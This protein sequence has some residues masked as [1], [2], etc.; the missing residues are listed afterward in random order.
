MPTY[1]TLKE[2]T[3]T[4]K[5]LECF[6]GGKQHWG[7]DGYNVRDRAVV[8]WRRTETCKKERK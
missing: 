8:R 4:D 7:N 5:G 2:M 1:F 3:H 6:A